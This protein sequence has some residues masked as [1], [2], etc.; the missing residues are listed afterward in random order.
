MHEPKGIALS[1]AVSYRRRR[2]VASTNSNLRFVSKAPR[3]HPFPTLSAPR[4][5]LGV[6]FPL[7]R[8]LAF[9]FA[10]VYALS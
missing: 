4:C 2:P 6:P 1:L 9:R 5:V 7:S 10:L 3:R 8:L